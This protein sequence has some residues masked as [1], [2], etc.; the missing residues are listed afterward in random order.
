MNIKILRKDSMS[1]EEVIIFIIKL[2]RNGFSR[3]NKSC[4]HHLETKEDK[5]NL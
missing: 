3:R 2:K 1:D 5:L 4:E